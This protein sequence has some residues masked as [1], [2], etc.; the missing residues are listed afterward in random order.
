MASVDW[1]KNR[2]GTNESIARMSHATRHDGKKVEYNNKN[3]NPD[4]TPLNETVGPRGAEMRTAKQEIE[5]LKKRIEYLDKARPPQRVRKNRVVTISFEVP[6]PDALPPDKELKFFNLAYQEISKI[7]GGYDN[8]TNGYIHNDEK[9]KYYDPLKKDFVMSRAHMHVQGIV[10][11]DDFGVNGKHFMTRERMRDLNKR[12]DERCRQELGVSFLKEEIS[13][14]HD[15][16]QSVED[17]KRKS[18]EKLTERVAELEDLNKRMLSEA[19]RQNQV[20]KSQENEIIQ[21][22]EKINLQDRMLNDLSLL[23]RAKQF[24]SGN[25]A[26][27]ALKLADELTSSRTAELNQELVGARSKAW[28]ADKRLRKQSEAYSN[29]KKENER[30]QAENSTLKHEN[31]I[32]SKALNTLQ[33]AFDRAEDLMKRIY[34]WVQFKNEFREQEPEFYHDFQEIRHDPGLHGNESKREYVQRETNLDFD[35]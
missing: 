14:H 17:L 6:T 19:E 20:I 4:L 2:G 1:Q 3:I 33:R 34:G 18:A 21:L 31:G 24:L 28:E 12:I 27:R 5:R 15:K 9:H 13:Q 16:W 25:E 26:D 32:L 30:L 23:D 11:T 7:C 10:W 35:R 22:Q 8:V 29:L